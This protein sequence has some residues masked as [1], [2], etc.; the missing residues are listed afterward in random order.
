VHA[1]AEAETEVQAPTARGVIDAAVI[2]Y[3]WDHHRVRL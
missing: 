1:L 2:S 3:F